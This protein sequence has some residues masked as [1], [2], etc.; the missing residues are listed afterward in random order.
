MSGDFAE[1]TAQYGPLPERAILVVAHPD[2]EVVGAGALLMRLK[3]PLVLH[4]TDGAP[5]NLHDARANGFDDWRGYAEA[6]RREAAAALALAGRVGQDCLGIPDQGAI[7]AAA[8]IARRLADRLGA[9]E[10]GAIITHAY[11]G[12]HPDH[13]AAALGVHL[14]C[15]LLRAAG[16]AVPPLYETGSYRGTENGVPVR[17]FLP[18]PGAGPA[19][20]LW[21]DEADR[22]LRDRMLDCHYTQRRTLGGF[23]GAA[24]E[25][26]RAAPPY[27]FTAPPHPNPLNYERHDWGATGET[28][29]AAA[30]EALETFGIA[31]GTCL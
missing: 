4:V 1:W 11:E 19:A 27:D 18:H 20:V 29:R 3:D 10:H 28:W 24:A 25:R 2:D 17:T 26:F 15:H 16:R 31:P 12:G 5:R 8:E 14:A 7:Y 9:E 30:R 13:D 21:L 6:R 23:Y 22:Q